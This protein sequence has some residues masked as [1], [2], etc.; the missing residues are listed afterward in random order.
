MMVNVLAQCIYFWFHIL[1]SPVNSFLYD[2]YICGCKDF[3]DGAP[4]KWFQLIKLLSQAHPILAKFLEDHRVHQFRQNM[5]SN[6]LRILKLELANYCE[7]YWFKQISNLTK[8]SS[9]G[10]RLAVF[11]SNFEEYLNNI[12]NP[13]HRHLLTRL[14]IG[15]HKL[16]RQVGAG[17][18]REK[19]G[20][21]PLVRVT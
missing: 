9:S 17:K 2:S 15:S 8:K 11:H 18:P 12:K 3:Y 20:N 7:T 14:I 10:G 21:V 19:I 13:N 5:P 4:N 16:W 6:I 1:Q